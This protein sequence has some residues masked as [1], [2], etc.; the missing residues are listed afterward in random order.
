MP[1]SPDPGPVWLELPEAVLFQ[2]AAELTDVGD[3][4][5]FRAACRACKRATSDPFVLHC[6]VHVGATAWTGEEP[7]SVPALG[8]ALD[9]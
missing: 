4:L 3:I 5:A 7:S 6:F 1:A 8:R 2:V 9:R